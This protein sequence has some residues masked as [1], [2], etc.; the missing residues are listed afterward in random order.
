M[1]VALYRVDWVVVTMVTDGAMLTIKGQAAFEYHQ[2][3]DFVRSIPGRLTTL[4]QNIQE[5]FNL[6]LKYAP[7]VVSGT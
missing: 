1:S 7:V 4:I 3:V 2:L 5:T 6:V